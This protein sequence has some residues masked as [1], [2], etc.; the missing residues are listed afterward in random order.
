MVLG[1]GF[2]TFAAATIILVINNFV[3]FIGVGI[4]TNRSNSKQTKNL[5]LGFN[6]NF[7]LCEEI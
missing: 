4:S 6:Q 7:D 5:Q 2:F 3:A 1:L